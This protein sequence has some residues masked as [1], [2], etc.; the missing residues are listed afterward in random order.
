MGNA[1]PRNQ[2]MSNNMQNPM[3]S[4]APR[5]QSMSNNVQNPY[6]N[7]PRNGSMTK[8][9]N[10]YNGMTGKPMQNKNSSRNGV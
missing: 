4:G 2:S 7:A 10:P 5:N 9:Q 6:N 3:G 1:A 8:M